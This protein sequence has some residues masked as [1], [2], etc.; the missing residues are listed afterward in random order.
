MIDTPIFWVLARTC[1]FAQRDA[2]LAGAIWYRR[3]RRYDT[4]TR[5]HDKTVK[6]KPDPCPEG[7]PPEGVRRY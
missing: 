4:T 6:T 2:L 5:R 3:H 1:K 7:V